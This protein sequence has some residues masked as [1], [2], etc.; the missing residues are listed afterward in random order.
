[1][2]HRGKCSGAQQR[3][4]KL[5]IQPIY[6]KTQAKHG[7][8]LAVL[9]LTHVKR[10]NVGHT[11]FQASFL[12]LLHNRYHSSALLASHQASRSLAHRHRPNVCVKKYLYDCHCN[13][14]R[15]SG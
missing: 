7:S 3:D 6:R 10:L 8:I 9:S 2:R 15:R 1:M 14:S 11:V 12:T 4:L 5:L 13:S